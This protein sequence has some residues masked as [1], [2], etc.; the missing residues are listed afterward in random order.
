MGENKPGL[1]KGTWRAVG[2]CGAGSRDPP[3]EV[4][5]E[6]HSRDQQLSAQVGK[7]RPVRGSDFRP[8]GFT[9]YFSA[10]P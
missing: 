4:D 8:L 10:R 7:L 5:R 1:W 3:V 9:T 6:G 2:R